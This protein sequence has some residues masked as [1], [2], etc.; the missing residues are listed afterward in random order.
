MHGASAEADRRACLVSRGRMRV[1]AVERRRESGREAGRGK[2]FAGLSAPNWA[3]CRKEGK[4]G[5]ERWAAGK[6][7]GAGRGERGGPD[8]FEL[9][10]W[11][12]VFYWAG[13]FSGFLLS[14]PFSI[15]NTTQI[16]FEFK[17]NLNSNP[18]HSTK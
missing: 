17:R 5:L 2:R 9:L 15:S 8:W 3:G 11:V 13:F 1:G 12:W 6:E 4:T 7:R 14:F 10:G 18:K 16:Y